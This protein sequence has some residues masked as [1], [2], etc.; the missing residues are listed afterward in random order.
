[1]VSWVDTDNAVLRIPREMSAKN[2][3]HRVVGLTER[4][5]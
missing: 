1:V 3:D 2:R 5:W 4:T